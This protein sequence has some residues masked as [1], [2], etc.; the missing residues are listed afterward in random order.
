MIHP[1]Q[2]KQFD[3]LKNAFAQNRLSHAYLLSGMAGLGKTN[4]ARE[5]AAFLLCESNR[6]AGGS[7][8]A[9]AREATISCTCR[10]CVLMRADNHP[11]FM[12]IKPE[13]KSR[14]IKIDQIREM[15]EKT[16]QTA[17]AGGYQVVII[18]P[19][20][21]MPVQAAN[22]LLKTL[23]EPSGK[24]IIFLID[25]Q[26]SVLPPTIMSRCQKIFFSANQVDLRLHDNQLTLRDELLNH[27]EE[28][29]SRR[30]N[31]ILFNQAWL[32]IELENIF[33]KLILLCA[34]LSRLQFANNMSL[35]I[36]YDAH[37]KLS[38]MASKITPMALQKFIDK[39]LDKKLMTA[40]GINLNQQLCLEDMFI[41]WENV[42]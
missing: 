41:E 7:R 34:D 19:A 25:N 28:I 13:E 14:V 18:S 20:D 42:L 38:Q 39:L 17:H 31:P 11:D 30:V 5:F 2:Q 4:F 3:T 8:R 9:M 37:E 16:A 26:K 21:S 1:T 33:Q 22:A 10:G 23:E 32:K 15:C 29:Q 27:L 24:I 40:K 35:I 6:S 12:L 36:N